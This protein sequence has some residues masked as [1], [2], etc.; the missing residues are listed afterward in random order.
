MDL[1]RR[2]QAAQEQ[3]APPAHEADQIALREVEDKATETLRQIIAAHGWTGRS[4]VGE[5]GAAAAWWIAQ[6]ATA[7]PEF[8]QHALAL[9]E[10][11]VHVGEATPKQVAYLT[12]RR[13]IIAGQPQL[14][15]TQFSYMQTGTPVPYAI[16]DPDELDAR[17]AEMGLE[18]FDVFEVL[19]RTLYPP[20]EPPTA[21]STAC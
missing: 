18:P 19:I 11:A 8:Q 6:H 7:N 1:K 4:L 12:D 3:A 21:E 13:R 14:Y 9:V 16:D 5:I 15:G 10:G 17:R 2:H 20:L